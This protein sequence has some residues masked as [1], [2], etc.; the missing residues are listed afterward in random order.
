MRRLTLLSLL[1][2]LVACQQ[3]PTDTLGVDE[4]SWQFTVATDTDPPCTNGDC[5]PEDPPCTNGDCPPDDP[6]CTNGDCP[7]DDP[8][9]TNGDCPPDDPPCTNG[10]CPGGGGKVK[11]EVCHRTMN[12]SYNLINIGEPAFDAHIDHGDAAPGEPVPEL[13]GY[14]FDDACAPVGG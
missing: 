9:C 6:P 3:T 10:D 7:P 1:L 4:E 11:V 8:P 12:G 14:L 2:F 5:L 13:P